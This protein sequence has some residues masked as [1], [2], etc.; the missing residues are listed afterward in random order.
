ME[1]ESVRKTQTEGKLEIENFGTQIGNSDA[2]LTNRIREIE[3]RISGI[4]D[5]VKEMDTL[6]KENVKSK[7]NQG[8]KHPGNLAHD[9]KI[10]SRN[11]GERHRKYF[12]QNHGR[13]FP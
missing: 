11:P 9:E 13:L 10:K 2:N 8:M 6:V 4:K 12:Q 7:I 5:K 3:K 1:K